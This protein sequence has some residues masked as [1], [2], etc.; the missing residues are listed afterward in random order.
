[1]DTRLIIDEPA[2]GSWNMAVD[3]ALLR[4]AGQGQRG[5]AALRFYRWQE[6]TLSLGYFQEFGARCRHLPSSKLPLVRRTTGGGAIVHDRE[7]T[8]SFV[9]PIRNRFSAAIQDV[10]KLFHQTLIETLADHG[11]EA[12]RIDLGHR[13]HDRRKRT[14]CEPARASRG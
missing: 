9:M 7:L 11:I 3:E 12:R 6:P 2:R 14:A 8:Y 4:W 5:G 1:M 13:A 10:V